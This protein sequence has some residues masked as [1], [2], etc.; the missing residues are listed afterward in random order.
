MSGCQL[1]LWRFGRGRLRPVAQCDDVEP[2]A[3]SVE[4]DGTVHP[5]AS[6][7]SLAPVPELDGYWFE[8]ADVT[9]DPQVVINRLTP[10][11]GRLLDAE[12]ETLNLAK[13]LAARYEE[14][15]VLYTISEV[16]GRS[17]NIHDAAR[18]IL[19][20]VASVVGA[21]RASIFLYDA[22]SQLLR[23]MAA[24]GRV[25]EELTPV[26]VGDPR[27][28]T[29]RVFRDAR[30]IT[31]DP[32]HDDDPPEGVHAERGYRGRAFLSIPIPSPDAAGADQPIGVINLTDRLG[33]DAFSGGQRR[34]VSAVASQIGAAIEHARLVQR[35][36][37]RQRL[38]RELELAKD[39][40][41]KLAP[42]HVNLGADV[43]LAARCDPA[44]RVGGD[45]YHFVRLG[46]GRIGVMLGDVSSHG[47][48]AAMIMAMVRAAAG[49][50]VH[51][52]T[53]PDAVLRELLES[54]ADELGDTEMFLTLFFGILDGAGGV[55]RYANAGHPH[56]FRLTAAGEC[57]RLAATSPPLGITAPEEIAAAEAP[58]HP[59][60]DL[61]LLFSDGL[62]DASN[63]AGERFG[64]DRMLDIVRERRTE[65]CQAI[66]DAVFAAVEAF[67]PSSRDDRTVVLVRI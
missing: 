36:V 27:A 10:I 8:V 65:S 39:L 59:H 7:R 54:V 15:E 38:E 49:I 41:R 9:G 28:I 25:L 60:D 62:V 45:F 11:L 6:G 13:Q 14:I 48:A 51:E 47:F 1:R 63:E 22:A 55:V 64:E 18:T 19:E 16:V 12:R 40:Q 23:P 52:A 42:Q 30:L 37:A 58:W 44:E 26:A 4:E 20:E 21:E 53:T 34:L 29:A 46:G 32:R 57:Q 50:H 17:V 35:D 66:L 61:L 3:V 31:Y 24:V 43:D 67:E 56:A 2:P 5:A 33:S